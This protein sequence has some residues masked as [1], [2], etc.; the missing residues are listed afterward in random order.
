VLAEADAMREVSET[1]L[2]L[3]VK[4]ELTPCVKLPVPPRE[5]SMVMLFVFVSVPSTIKSLKVVVPIIDF[6]APLN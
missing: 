6:A 3:I 2:P 5:P 1:G 4:F